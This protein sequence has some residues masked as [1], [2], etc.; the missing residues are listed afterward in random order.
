MTA[1]AKSIVSAEYPTY[2]LINRTNI[3]KKIPRVARLP[4]QS[5]RPCDLPPPEKY[6]VGYSIKLIVEGISLVFMLGRI[7][8]L[9][10]GIR[11]KVP[12]LKALGTQ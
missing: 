1:S 2:L 3:F 12:I 10:F 6:V 8:W 5:V 4:P 7:I 9:G 11:R